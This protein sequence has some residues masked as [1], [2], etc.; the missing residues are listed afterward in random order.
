MGKTGRIRA[1]K[2]LGQAFCE[3]RI[4]G[5]A[6]FRLWEGMAEKKGD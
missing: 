1:K 5:Y 6:A 2:G 4:V 3:W